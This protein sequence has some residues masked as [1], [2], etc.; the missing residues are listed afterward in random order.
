MAQ[1]SAFTI[2]ERWYEQPVDHAKPQDEIY[3]QQIIMLSPK[4]VDNESDVL[5][6]LGNETDAT[7]ENL[8]KLYRAYGSP[9]DVIFITAEHR[10]YGQSIS[11][12]PQTIPRY[13]SANAALQDYNRL[14]VDLKKTYTGNWMVAGYSYGGAL[15]INFGHQSPETADAILA[16]SAP[17]HWP[18]QIP[19]YDQQVIKSLG[20]G[21]TSRLHQHSKSLTPEKLFDQNWQDRELLTALTVGLSQN[22]DSQTYKP[23]INALSYLPTS[24]FLK[25]LHAILPEEAHAWS[26]HRIAAP[27]DHKAARSGAFNWYTWKYQQCNE[28]GTFFDQGAFSYKKQDHVEDC[29]ATFGNNPEF[30]DRPRW[31]VASMLAQLSIPITVVSGGRDPWIHLGVKPDHHYSNITYFYDENG[32]H[33]PDR[34]SQSFG[35]AVFTSLRNSISEQ[36]N[37]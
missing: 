31:D 2:A 32:Y 5:F 4:T 35:T 20:Q 17:V 23:Y 22:A 10:G 12:G 30:F 16:S 11:R 26:L 13:V 6:V 19:Q 9:Q 3:K 18:F 36:K 34:D 25:A 29:I 14:I 7:Q 33:C 24:V 15:A 37:K 28:L 21:L 8:V 1:D 27:L